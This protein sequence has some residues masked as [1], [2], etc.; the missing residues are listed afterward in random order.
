LGGIRG[1]EELKK[2]V[3]S[4]GMKVA[5]ALYPVSMKQLITIADSGKNIYASQ[6]NMVRT[7]APKRP[8]SFTCSISFFSVSSVNLCGALCNKKNIRTYTE[9]HRKHTED[10]EKIKYPSPIYNVSFIIFVIPVIIDDV[11][12]CCKYISL[13]KELPT[14]LNWLLYLKQNLPAIFW[15]H[16]MPGKDYSARTGSGIDSKERSASLTILNGI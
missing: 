2:R 16:T 5:F 10:M 15:K 13:K 3:D 7:K 14:V 1:L 12:Y 6:I 8:C 4:G 11:R 9:I